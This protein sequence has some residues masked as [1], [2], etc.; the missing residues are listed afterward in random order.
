VRV[1]IWESLTEK[2]Q[3]EKGRRKSRSWSPLSLSEE[4]T[5]F[6]TSIWVIGCAR[7]VLKGV[8]ER[9]TGEDMT[10]S[11]YTNSFL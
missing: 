4:R 9:G 2:V 1:P 11:G 8:K 3:G 5:R 6:R 10:R 7:G